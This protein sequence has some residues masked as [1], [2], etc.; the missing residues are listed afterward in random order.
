MNPRLPTFTVALLA[1]I[2]SISPTNAVQGVL[3]STTVL[4]TMVN[5]GQYYGGCMAQLGKAI[6]TATNSPNCP[7]NWVS[8]SC[9]GLYTSKEQA[10]HMLD[11]AQLA[12]A[13]NKSVS[14]TVEDTKKHN[15]YCFAQR[16]EII[17]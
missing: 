3:S 10:F 6:N 13:L 1:T 4:R 7:G 11:H 9:V 5:S 2:A 14:V 15:D 8:F 12:L 17:K 16:I